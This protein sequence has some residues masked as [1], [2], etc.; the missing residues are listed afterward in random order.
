MEELCELNIYLHSSDQSY[1][2]RWEGQQKQY[3]QNSDVRHKKKREA[4]SFLQLYALF[5]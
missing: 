4:G 2:H 5:P 1:R 3:I